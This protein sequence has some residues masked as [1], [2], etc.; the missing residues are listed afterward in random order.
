MLYSDSLW[1]VVSLGSLCIA[2]VKNVKVTGSG[3]TLKD[4]PYILPVDKRPKEEI[5]VSA[6]AYPNAHARFIVDGK[7]GKI[8]AGSGDASNI[9]STVSSRIVW[10]PGM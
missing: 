8:R 6:Y 5:Q 4:C 9:D 1:N 2:A 10:V 7:T 3:W